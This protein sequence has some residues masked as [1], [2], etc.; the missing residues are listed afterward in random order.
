MTLEGGEIRGDGIVES[1][2]LDD[3]VDEGG[4]DDEKEEGAKRFWEREWV[5]GDAKEPGQSKLGEEDSRDK[6]KYTGER[7]GCHLV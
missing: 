2:G 7:E 5:D 1:D 4:K 3:E 6:Y